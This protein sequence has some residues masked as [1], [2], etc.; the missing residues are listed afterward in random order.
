MSPAEITD[1]LIAEVAEPYGFSLAQ[2]KGLRS[3]RPLAT[4]RAKAYAVVRER[5]GFSLTQTARVFGGRDHTTILHGIRQ[6]EA[7]MAWIEVLKAC[8][9]AEDQMDLFERLAA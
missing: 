8:V 9:P 3:K 7:R 5:R 2:M 4:V 1:A 6:H